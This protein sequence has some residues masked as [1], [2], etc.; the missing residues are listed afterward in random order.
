MR[1]PIV[2]ALSL[3]FSGVAIAQKERKKRK[4]TDTGPP[5]EVPLPSGPRLREISSADRSFPILI[6][7]SS[8]EKSWG[9]ES[10]TIINREFGFVTPGNAYKQS[11]IHPEPG[12]WKWAKADEWVER[13]AANRQIMRLHGPIS[14]QC[15]TWAKDDA[16]TGDEL[17]E[18]LREFMTALCQRYNDSAHVRWMDVVNETVT[19]EG[20]WFGPREGS[21]KW[22]NPWTKIGFDE[23]HELKPPL[24]IKL[25]FEIANEHAPNLRQM[26][27]QHGD[28]EKPMWQKIAKT[29]I[30][31]REQGLRV[32]GIGWQAHVNAGFEKDPENMKNLNA[33]I[34]WA[35]SNDLEFHVTENTVW[36]KKEYENDYDAQ[37]E[38]FRAILRTLIAHRDSGVVTWNAWQIRDSETQHPEWQGCLF[39]TEGQPK[40]AY[41]AIQSELEEVSRELRN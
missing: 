31:L 22:E 28:M 5:P 9:T 41:Y 10:E 26:I 29:V 15:S 38:T 21:D 34:R 30:Y 13:C 4:P 12:V 20:E 8:N 37:T 25:A 16:R 32:D 11:A 1:L 24:Y 7:A 23:T 6:G 35:H 36:L 3:L 39:D 18:N 2:L 19:R 27:N 40:K 17:R 33:M 14:P